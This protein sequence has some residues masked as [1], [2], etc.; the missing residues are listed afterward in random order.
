MVVR[1]ARSPR[2]RPP[3]RAPRRLHRH[4]GRLLPR[5]RREH[6]LGGVQRAPRRASRASG[7]AGTPGRRSPG[8]R[9]RR[10]FCGRWLGGRPLR[11]GV[12]RRIVNAS[13]TE[14]AAGLRSNSWGSRCGRAART[15]PTELHHRAPPRGPPSRLSPQPRRR[16]PRRASSSGLPAD[17]LVTFGQALRL[18]SRM[19]R[20]RDRRGPRHAAPFRRSLGALGLD[21]RGR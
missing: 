16:H 21:P 5:P 12:D 14:F 17:S 9:W 7:R 18:G 1:A 19:G 3:G 13:N 8:G 6:G 4:P 15:R 11:W 2:P 20:S 10:F